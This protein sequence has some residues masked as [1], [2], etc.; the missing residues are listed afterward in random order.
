[1]ARTI[2][3][4]L[5][6]GHGG[7]IS[8]D[9]GGGAVTFNV[10]AYLAPTTADLATGLQ[11]ALNASVPL[12]GA[13]VVVWS[14]TTGKVT[15]SS[16]V[17]FALTLTAAAQSVLGFTSAT[18]AAAASRTGEAIAGYVVQCLGVELSAPTSAQEVRSEALR[19][20]RVEATVWGQGRRWRVHAYVRD[21]LLP[22]TRAWFQNRVRITP[23]SDTTALT[24][25]NLDG[26]VTCAVLSATWATVQ[27]GI[28]EW[29][30]EVVEVPT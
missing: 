1:M 4:Y 14:P 13:Y 19:H 15:I 11:T 17:A 3:A 29:R 18:Y 27:E 23:G 6:V 20:G 25:Y 9:E 26:A 22:P 8:V 21:T 10:P 28:T 12:A 7:S 2:E 30:A 16:S 5:E 24:E